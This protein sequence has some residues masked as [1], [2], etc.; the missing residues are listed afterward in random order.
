MRGHATACECEEHACNRHALSP[1]AY[2][3]MHIKALKNKKHAQ[4]CG[5][6]RIYASVTAT[7]S[8][9]AKSCKHSIYYVGTQIPVNYEHAKASERMLE[10]VHMYAHEPVNAD[11][12]M[13]S[14]NKM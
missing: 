9:S 6:R 3:N 2:S 13:Q 11:E 8:E 10:Q 14:C 12:N 5:H 7:V 1:C 4:A